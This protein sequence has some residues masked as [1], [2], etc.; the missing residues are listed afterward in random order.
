MV[1]CSLIACETFVT[2]KITRTATRIKLGLQ[3]K[4]YLGNLDAKRDWGHAEDYV[5]AMWRIFQHDEADDF[6]VATGESYSVREFVERV[7][8]GLNLD[9]EEHV[10]IDPRYYRPTEVE[11]LH[12]DPSKVKRVLGWEPKV[13][14]SELV[15]RMVKHNLDLAKQEKTLVEAGHRFTA[16]GAASN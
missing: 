9:W 8:S 15:Q 2:R 14:F 11:Y 4:L 7:F 13:T 3:R 10:L 1:C 12:G 5:D 6:V 16:R